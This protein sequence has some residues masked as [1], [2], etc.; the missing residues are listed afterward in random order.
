MQL[1]DDL[2]DVCVAA[3]VKLRFFDG[4]LLLCADAVVTYLKW[5][6]DGC[7]SIVQNFAFFYL[8]FGFKIIENV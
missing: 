5:Y 2:G 1:C 7:C 6:C 3:G 8:K 4:T